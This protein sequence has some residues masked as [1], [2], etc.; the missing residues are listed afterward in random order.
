MARPSRR[1]SDGNNTAE[2]VALQ[3]GLSELVSR[4]ELH[5]LE[6]RINSMT[7]IRDAWSGNDP[8]EPGVETCS[9]AI[10]AAL[11]SVPN[12]WD[13]HLAD[14]NPKPADALATVGADIASLGPG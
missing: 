1:V 11:S 2:Y 4:Y 13:T 10:A 8:T 12:N 14:R 5:S 7:V 6:I 9:K 3:L